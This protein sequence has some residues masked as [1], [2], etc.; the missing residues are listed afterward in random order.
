LGFNGRKD[1]H[2]NYHKISLRKGERPI[3]CNC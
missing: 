1:K 2:L 3:G